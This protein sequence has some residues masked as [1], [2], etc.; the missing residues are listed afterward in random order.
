MIISRFQ[1]Y[2]LPI[3]NLS[4][5]FLLLVQPY[6]GAIAAK[7]E[8]VT[9]A[10]FE[11][12]D[13]TRVELLQ[14]AY[15]SLSASLASSPSLESQALMGKSPYRLYITSTLQPP[16]THIATTSQ[17]LINTSIHC[18]SA[19][20]NYLTATSQRPDDYLAHMF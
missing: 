12:K 15:N 8:L 19:A 5:L 16:V 13:F 6:Y 1:Q 4:L 3:C 20:Y 10:W 9:H 11:Q 18:T 7:L 17:H 2:N 14:E